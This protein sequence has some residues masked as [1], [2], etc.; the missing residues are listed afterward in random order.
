MKKLEFKQKLFF[1]YSLIVLSVILL[2]F[3]AIYAYI[4]GR[5]KVEILNNMELSAKEMTGQLDNKIQEMDRLTIEVVSNPFIQEYSQDMKAKG[6]P[7][8][9][10]NMQ[11]MAYNTLISI[12]A[13]NLGSMRVSIYNRFGSYISIGIPDSQKKITARTEDPEYREWYKSILPERNGSR[14]LLPHEDFWSADGKEEMIS[15]LREIVDINSYA[16]LGVV[17][18]QYPVKKLEDMFDS[19]LMQ[20]QYLIT[21]DGGIIYENTFEENAA[22][23]ELAACLGKADRGMTEGKVGGKESY[24]CYEK[25]ETTG[26]YF[27]VVKP[28]RVLWEAA[29]PV[30]GVALLLAAM[31]LVITLI[32]IGLVANRLTRP[33]KKLKEQI[34]S[35]DRATETAV[36]PEEAEEKDEI[37]LIHTAFDSLYKNLQLSR[38]ELY[39]VRLQE[40]KTQMLAVQAQMNPHFLYNILSVISAVGFKYQ[41][42]EIMDI[43]KYLSDMLRYAGAFSLDKV[44]MAEE[45]AHTAN[46]LELMKCRFKDRITYEIITQEGVEKVRVPKLILQPIVENC[47]QHGLKGVKPP[48]VIRIEI[49][50]DERDW[51]IRVGDNGKGFDREAV[52]ML[53]KQLENWQDNLNDD[54]ASL[55]IGGYGLTNVLIRLKISYGK[56]CTFKVYER[57]W[58]SNKFC[59]VEIGGE[60]GV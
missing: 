9:Y 23:G 13:V 3:G 43:C 12:S 36:S 46:Y 45:I 16:S 6:V 10:S 60:I 27:L 41:A 14:K 20:G 55:G 51:W 33:L 7:N 37:L 19:G 58:A 56:S 52:E 35:V 2:G 40:A 59:T 15:V 31:L 18:I 11:N 47:F 57:E 25:S 29:L 24:V 34:R 1:Y 8:S 5:L 30:A 50:K 49:G 22:A 4:M 26:W 28:K 39:Y 42:A 21:A 53:K 48:W 32:F 38:D 17:E 44:R 54:I